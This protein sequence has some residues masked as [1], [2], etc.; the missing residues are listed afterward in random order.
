MDESCVILFYKYTKVTDPSYYAREHQERCEQLDLQGKVRIANEGIN[1][2]LAGKRVAIDAYLDWIIGTDLFTDDE[3]ARLIKTH[4]NHDQNRYTFFK[5][6]TGCRHVFA[7]LSVKVVKEICPLGRPD[8]IGVEQLLNDPMQSTGKLPPAEFH[9]ML[10]SHATDPDTIVLDTRNYYESRIGA[11]KG[12]KTPAIRKFGRFPDYVDRNR[13]A[14]EGKTI[15]TYCTGYVHNRIHDNM[16]LL[17]CWIYR[18]IRCEKATAYMRHAL[19]NDTQIFMLDG[20]IH[21]YLEWCKANGIRQNNN[22]DGPL[23]IGKNYVFDGRQGLALEEEDDKRQVLGKCQ[24]C[25][26]PWDDYRK[27][28]S[29]HCHL[30]ILYC[31]SCVPADENAYCCQDCQQ[32][33]RGEDGVCGCERQRRQEEMK[34]LCV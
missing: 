33:I 27:C 19:S 31:H 13:Q 8:I 24:R 10:L 5:P 34:P 6:S 16:G 1:T 20:G 29:T 32:G 3:R 2:T 9:D 14:L 11:F 4:P 30:L 17:I 28:S 15:F 21:N 7:D 12:A 22:E 18:G 26:Q 25:S 23:W